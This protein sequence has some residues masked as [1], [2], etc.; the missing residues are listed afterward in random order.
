MP[1]ALIEPAMDEEEAVLV[2]KSAWELYDVLLSDTACALLSHCSGMCRWDLTGDCFTYATIASVKDYHM[3]LFVASTIFLGPS[4]VMSV[5][6]LVLRLRLIRRK[7]RHRD[8]A[9]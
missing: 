8:L 6:N 3:D 9:E 5:V 1:L 7:V 4:V 2:L